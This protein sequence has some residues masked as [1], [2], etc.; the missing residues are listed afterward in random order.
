MCRSFVLANDFSNCAATG[1]AYRVPIP[2]QFVDFYGKGYIFGVLYY[3]TRDASNDKT[4]CSSNIMNLLL[5][6][7][8]VGLIYL[9][10]STDSD[11]ASEHRREE[12]K[13]LWQKGRV[14]HAGD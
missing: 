1:D 13:L 7:A 11:K 14:I 3:S 8:E 5:L 4:D 12:V 2:F 6:Y 9:I 10:I